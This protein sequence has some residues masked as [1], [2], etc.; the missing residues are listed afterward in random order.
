MRSEQDSCQTKK[1]VRAS[2]LAKN[3]NAGDLLILRCH[4]NARQ[5]GSATFSEKPLPEN[6]DP[7]LIYCQ[8]SFALLVNSSRQLA[9]PVGDLGRIRIAGVFLGFFEN[10]RLQQPCVLLVEFDRHQIIPF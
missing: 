10:D 3:Q 6:F 5:C 2:A 8:Q 1:V 7:L 4:G 9:Q